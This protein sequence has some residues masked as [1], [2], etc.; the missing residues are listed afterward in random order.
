MSALDRSRKTEFAGMGEAY[1][2]ARPSYPAA[3]FRE[4]DNH[5]HF[6]MGQ[7]ALE[8]GCGTGKATVHLATCGLDVTAI[9]IAPDLLD[10]AHTKLQG[11]KVKLVK[12][13]FEDF[14]ARDH[15][16]DYI[17]AA[18]AFH[19]IDP[20]IACPKTHKLLKKDGALI[21]I[22]NIRWN[23]DNEERRALDKIYQEHAPALARNQAGGK[24]AATGTSETAY[25]EAKT[26]LEKAVGEGQFR[27]LKSFSVRWQQTLSAIEYVAL[28]GTYSDHARLQPAEK[29]KL[30]AAVEK[31]INERGSKIVVPYDCVALTAI[32][33]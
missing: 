11:G 21:L 33:A 15:S 10:I 31:L 1:D 30:Y 3:L 17:A 6:K 13:S 27:D 32:A 22:W 14:T 24:S 4:L 23:E 28:L 12:S 19:W 25:R 16:F 7:K 26:T 9:D 8:I 29:E 18:Q 2:R 20:A 5:F